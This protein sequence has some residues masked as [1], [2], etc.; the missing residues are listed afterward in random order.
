MKRWV[1]MN[2]GLALVFGAPAFLNAPL[3]L[4]AV[5]GLAAL[6]I[7]VL[8]QKWGVR[9]GLNDLAL[10]LLFGPLLTAGISLA[11]FAEWGIRDLAVGAAFGALTLWVFQLRH[12]ENQFRAN[13]ANARTFLGHLSFDQARW[14]CA[15]EAGLLL[16]IQPLVAL[17]LDVPLIFL[18]VAPLVSVP[19]IFTVQR[20]LKAASPL[21]S[22]LVNSSRWAL[23]SHLAWTLWWI[24]ALGVQ[25]L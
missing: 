21:S 12:F 3:Q 7:A 22:S 15:T 14:I 2:L 17:Y 19:L 25:W 5:C 1:W 13:P 11:S 6:S 24:L 9:F 16:I 20:F 8:N 10:V 4:T 23:G 18:A